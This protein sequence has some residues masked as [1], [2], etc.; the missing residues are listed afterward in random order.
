MKRATF[1]FILIYLI[2]FP[3]IAQLENPLKER[4]VPTLNGHMFPTSSHLNSSFINTSLQ[5]N[6]GFGNTSKLKVP[7]IFIGDYEILSFEG[8]ITFFNTDIQYQQRF[9]PWLALY[10]SFR[11]SG[12]LGSDIST[13]MADGIN[14]LSGGDI[15]WLIRIT[16]NKKFNLSGNIGVQNLS[17]NFINVTKY[18]EDLIDNKPNPSVT[19]KI[20]ILIVGAGIRGAYAFN[21]TYG[22]QFQGDVNYG[23][24][25]QREK[26]KAFY[27]GGLMG[28]IDFLPKYNTAIGLALGYALTSAPEIVM[29]DGGLSHIITGRVGYTGSDEFELGVQYSY[30]NVRLKSVEDKPFIGKILLTLK[31]YF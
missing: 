8:R 5:A 20:P 1:I 22:L 29:Q 11:I 26:S 31:F 13:I 30:Y 25:F 16:H 6:L 24:S 2:H 28:D 10:L 27:S 12:R 21:E 18:F 7:G 15:G 3:V 17:G 23:E 19:E 9:T 4:K 14:T